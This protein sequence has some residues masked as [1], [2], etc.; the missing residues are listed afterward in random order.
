MGLREYQNCGYQNRGLVYH[1]CFRSLI[2]LR[3]LL[4]SGSISA[5][6]LD[7]FDVGPT[8]AIVRW[9]SFN[10]SDER[11][12]LGWIINYRET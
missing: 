8:F 10:T 6:T 7:V 11:E 12:V 4:I 1:Y 9:S 5:V 3:L 2:V